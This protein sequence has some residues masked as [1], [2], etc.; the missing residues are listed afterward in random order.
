[1]KKQSQTSKAISMLIVLTAFST[2]ANAQWNL[3]GNTTSAPNNVLG[4]N[5]ATDL[6]IRTNGIT[7]MFIKNN[8]G[9]IGIGTAAPGFLLDIQNTGNASMNFKSATGNANILIERGT[10]ANSASVNYRTGGAASWQTGNINDNNFTINNVGVRASMTILKT[11]N[12][13]GIGITSPTQ[14]FQ[15]AGIIHSTTGGI[16]F[17]NATTQT[18]AFIPY[19]NGTGI[20]ITGTAITNTAP[21]Q[22]VVLTGSG[23]TTVTGTYPNFTIS[24]TDNNTAYTAGTGIS[25][26]GTVINS[27]WT[28]TGNNV[29]NNNTGNIGIG[30][31][32]PAARLHVADSSVV[33]SASGIIPGTAGAPPISGQGRRMMWYA[34]KAAFRVGY[35]DD[36]SWDKDSIGNYS[37]A[38]GYK[39]KANGIVSTEMGAFTTASGS[40]STATGNN[41]KASGSSST[42][43]GS[44]TTASGGQSTAMG[45]ITTASGSQST[46]MGYTTT[47]SGDYSTAM[48][49]NTKA[50][51]YSSL[52][53]GRYNDTTSVSLLHGMQQIRFLLQVTAAAALREA[54]HLQF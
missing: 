19:T 7:R 20:N 9:F 3:T 5:N 36:A 27:V 46:A 41:T 1:M 2:F 51:S 30:T 28:K 29:F 22:A 35:V 17:P 53:I 52:V 54:M 13:V 38:C 14:K 16:M 40:Y 10:S 26:A 15:V 11:N 48:G 34:D 31:S 32:A 44:A 24:S 37:F 50:K 12:N 42:A 18:T 43:M 6:D 4:T 39:S 33:F 23:A 49:F 8:N 45:F 47:A 25:L 21:D